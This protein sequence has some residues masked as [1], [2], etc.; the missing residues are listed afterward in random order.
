MV[1]EKSQIIILNTNFTGAFARF[2]SIIS[3]FENYEIQS[4]FSSCFFFSNSA[5]ETLID[6]TNS[7]LIIDNS[8]F[9]NN[10]N[11]LFSVEASQFTLTV[12]KINNHFCDLETSGCLIKTSENSSIVIEN[13]VVINASSFVLEGNFYTENANISIKN[14]KFT[15][16]KNVH[17][18]GVCASIYGSIFIIQNS[19]FANYQKN[20]IFSKKKSQIFI[21]SSNFSEENSTFPS[22]S[23]LYGTIFCEDCLNF[24]IFNS[25]LGYN[26]KIFR[27]A[28]IYLTSTKSDILFE[29]SIS[30]ISSCT[31]F[32]NFATE[33]GGAI[34]IFDQNV[35]INN[36]SF[37]NNQA[38]NGGAISCINSRNM[39]IS[40]LIKSNKFESNFASVSGGAIKWLNN[41]PN[42]DDSNIFIKNHAKYGNNIATYPI[43]LKLEIYNKTNFVSSE[44]NKSSLIWDGSNNQ[45]IKIQD[46]SSGNEISYVFIIKIIDYYGKIVNLDDA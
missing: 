18:Q 38:S 42:I 3:L 41:L 36:N 16:L 15:N 4:T 14:S 9:E 44:L 31:F 29:S 24:T 28:G 13:I 22:E 20:C 32:S 27:G 7:E 17:L 30:T 35:T 46:V 10:S 8:K 43:R 39:T 25:F 23:N 45:T 12:S 33:N 40:I 5:F 26:R 6:I 34:C 19:S 2:G 1:N 37:L 11:I 21:F